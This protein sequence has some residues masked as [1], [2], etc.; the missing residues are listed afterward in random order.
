[1]KLKNIFNNMNEEEVVEEAREK[2][3]LL[4]NYEII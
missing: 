3:L 1:M 4:D 2:E